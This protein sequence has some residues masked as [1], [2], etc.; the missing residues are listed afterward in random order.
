MKAQYNIK[1]TVP[2]FNPNPIRE[3]ERFLKYMQW[4]LYLAAAVNDMKNLQM[5]ESEQFHQLTRVVLNDAKDCILAMKPED[6]KFSV[7]KSKL[8][9][10]FMN[11]SLYL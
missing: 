10:K 4:S 5:T 8:D 3:K 2:I 1:D 7:A 11:H 9:A 6:A